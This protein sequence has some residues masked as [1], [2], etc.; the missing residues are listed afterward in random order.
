MQSI[1]Y[2]LLFTFRRLLCAVLLM[3]LV[4]GATSTGTKP[5]VLTSISINNHLNG[6]AQLARMSCQHEKTWPGTLAKL[7]TFHAL[8][9]MIS[10][11]TA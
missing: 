3:A 10:N 11:L 5:G 8:A 2:D 9:A 1:V 7:R 4:S 6:S